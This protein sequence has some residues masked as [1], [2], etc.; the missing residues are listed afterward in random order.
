MVKDFLID[1]PDKFDDDDQDQY[2]Q[3]HIPQHNDLSTG[4]P[5]TLVRSA[6]D[7]S[8]N[9]T[10]KEHRTPCMKTLYVNLT[11]RG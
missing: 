2:R 9:L 5:K 6:V 10:V 1:T 7:F 3:Q 11:V 8:T 4:C